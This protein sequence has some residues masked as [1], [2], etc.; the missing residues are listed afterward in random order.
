MGLEKANGRHPQKGVRSG[1]TADTAVESDSNC[2]VAHR[3]QCRIVS[4]EVPCHLDEPESSIGEPHARNED[5]DDQGFGGEFGSMESDKNENEE[6]QDQV[7]NVESYASVSP[8][9][10][11]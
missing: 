2:S 10:E 11:S 3:C 8:A 1:F 7:N 9:Y 6:E 5:D 4:E